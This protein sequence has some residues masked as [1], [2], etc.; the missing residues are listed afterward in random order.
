M[1]ELSPNALLIPVGENWV[2]AMFGANRLIRGGHRVLWITRGLDGDAG[3][4]A[5]EA[6]SF[7]VP[8]EPAAD[9]GLAAPTAAETVTGILADA[10]LTAVPFNGEAEVVAAPV[11]PVRVG[12]YGGGG[13][14]MNQA[15]I[16]AACGFPVRFLSDAE[17]RAG[18]LAGVDVFIMPGG[19]TRAMNGQI[20]PLGDE[21]ARAIADFVRTGSMY[22]GCCAGTYDCIVNSESFLASCPAQA[23]LQL[24]NARPWQGE[25][26][27]EM[28]GGIQSPGV[29]VIEARTERP[30]HPVML[31]MPATFPL[32]HYNG[33][34]LDP[35]AESRLPGA[36]AAIGLASFAGTTERFTP[37]EAFAGPPPADEP[38]YVSLGIAAG[39]YAAAA[40]E[41]GTGRVVAFGSHPEL[42][43]DLALAEWFGAARMLA[44]AVLW[45]AV[46]R[47]GQ[48]PED[49]DQSLAG[50]MAW[51]LGSGFGEAARLTRVLT[52]QAKALQRQPLEPRPMW[53]APEY[54]MSTFGLSPDEIWRE[55]LVEIID[56][57]GR[58]GR[59]SAALA[60]RVQR[61]MQPRLGLVADEVRQAILAAEHRLL[62]NRADAWDQDGGYQG[63]LAL[64]HAA[65][66]MCD[67]ALA[68]WETELGPP[69]GPYGYLDTNP[70]HL[71]AG[72][73]LA[74]VGII[75]AVVQLLQ[76]TESELAMAELLGTDR[77]REPARELTT[78]GALP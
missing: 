44:N 4:A 35:I 76:Q 3:Q 54:A 23:H 27:I 71:V 16:L 78:A 55:S 22:I 62:Y 39:R 36:S 2:S 50:P 65:I 38:T 70:Y 58:A 18:G 40:G 46:S 49:R 25:S 9:P 74:A 30:D 59:Q 51:P 1:H 43:A 24:L 37:A 68:G 10:G 64:L 19:G 13:A 77:S 34:I 61:L 15:A 69:A 45:Q 57:A 29:G 8:L 20:E 11:A 5:A 7:L 26:A 67:Q 48:A 33:P 31:G 14:P 6:G 42:G 73:Y 21:G 17:V 53:L 63:V 75:G 47:Q 41:L 28:F 60:D 32:V 12:L 56:L 52:D 72:S 66:R